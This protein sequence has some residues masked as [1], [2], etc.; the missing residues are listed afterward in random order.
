MKNNDH[1]YVLAEHKAG[2]LVTLNSKFEVLS[3]IHTMGD[4]P[5]Q[6]SIDNTGQFIAVTNYSSASILICKLTDHIPN[7]VHSFITH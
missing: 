1:Y 5:C 6:A 7:T 4:D 2:L 3:R